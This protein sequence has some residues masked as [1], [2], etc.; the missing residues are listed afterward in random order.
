MVDPI[1]KLALSPMIQGA[2]RQVDN[3]GR[4][5]RQKAEAQ[6]AVH[7]RDVGNVGHAIIYHQLVG[8]AGQDSDERDT[9]PVAER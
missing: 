3:D 6:E 7:Q 8:N 1:S 9:D 5:H 2:H 4:A